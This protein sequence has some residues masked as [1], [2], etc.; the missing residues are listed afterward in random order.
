MLS[1]AAA[2]FTHNGPFKSQCI[3]SSSISRFDA[4]QIHK[5]IITVWVRACV[6]VHVR[7]NFRA[8]SRGELRECVSQ[9]GRIESVSECLCVRERER[10]KERE[11][12]CERKEFSK[13]TRIC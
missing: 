7:E 5:K 13:I 8:A 1:S 10:K 12:E 9:G 6:C 11:T 4:I 2:P 3:N